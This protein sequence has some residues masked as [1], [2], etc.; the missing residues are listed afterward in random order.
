MRTK[1]LPSMTLVVALSAGVAACDNN[2]AGRTL[3]RDVYA[4]P[5]AL[6]NCIADWGTA[7]LCKQPLSDEDKKKLG[8]SS[9]T[10]GAHNVLLWGPG[11]FGSNRTAAH[12][13]V[14]RTPTTTHAVRTAQ[15]KGG[16]PVSFSAPARG[17]FG[18]TG[19]SMGFSGS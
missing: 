13:G 3:Q 4:G 12:N 19:R 5:E 6:Q 16:A 11:Y 17:G 15:W 7:E 2:S 18:G 14:W 1:R 10:S 9:F 8:T